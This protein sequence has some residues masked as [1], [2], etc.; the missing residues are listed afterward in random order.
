[1]HESSPTLSLPAAS[2]RGELRLSTLVIDELPAP[3][4]RDQTREVDREKIDATD[5]FAAPTS[6]KSTGKRSLWALADQGVVS[7]GNCAT[8]VL[9]A[10]G[11][12]SSQFGSFAILL[13]AMIFLNTLQ[14]ALVI[15]PLSVRGAVLDR[16]GLRKLA[17]LCLLFT[18]AL[19][20]PLGV[21][22]FGAADAVTTPLVGILAVLALVLW[23][24]QETLRRAMMAH[25]GQKQCL[26]GDVVSYLGQASLVF[27]LV[28]TRSLTVERA[29][30]IMGLTSAASVGVQVW[31]IGPRFDSLRAL[32]KTMRDFFTLGRW[33]MLANFTAVITTLSCSW[34][35]AYFHGTGAVGQFQALANLMK[36]S[37]PL[38][39]CMAG[40]IVPAAARAFR[41]HGINA[42]QRVAFRYGLLTAAAIAPYFLFLVLFPTTS[43]HLLYGAGSEYTPLGNQLRAFVAWYSALIVAQV[44]GC[45]LNAIEQSRR[46]FI[47]QLAQAAAVILVTLPLT[48][49]YGL[50]GL[51]LGGVIGNC[52]M[53]AA[54]GVMVRHINEDPEAEHARFVADEMQQAGSAATF[55]SRLRTS[56]L[57]A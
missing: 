31:Q 3:W 5:D 36:L 15:Y 13:E 51:L 20:V 22:I 10:R 41:T 18:L 11:L 48:A 12:A 8:N 28:M 34:V 4:T 42:A 50:D 25:G 38:T 14:A 29:F 16:D 35:L 43:L 45:Y 6:A 54:Y 1:M 24:C 17:G 32:W 21:G 55:R 30:A 33:V 37:N 52:V 40:L 19:S 57:A 26:P 23:Q 47:A 7:L 44:A 56:R 49:L 27:A 53:A 2:R 39:I 9:L 46:G